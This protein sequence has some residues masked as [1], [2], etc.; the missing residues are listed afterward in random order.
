MLRSPDGCNVEDCDELEIQPMSQSPLVLGYL[1]TVQ[2]FSAIVGTS[3]LREII[4]KKITRDCL[5]RP[6]YNIERKRIELEDIGLM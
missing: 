1:P 4:L 3:H 2:P 5:R 6:V